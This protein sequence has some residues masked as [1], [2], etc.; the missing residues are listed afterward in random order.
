MT[1]GDSTIP[2][3]NHK[4]DHYHGKNASLYEEKRRH[5]PMWEREQKAVAAFVERGVVLD[6]PCGTG[7]FFDIYKAK[8]LGFLGLD[9]SA[10]MLAQAR[11]KD[12]EARLVEGSVFDIN[13]TLGETFGTVV[14]VRLLHWLNWPEVIDALGILSRVSDTLVVSIGLGDEGFKGGTFDHDEN[15]W[16]ALI[17]DNHE[18]VWLETNEGRNTWWLYKIQLQ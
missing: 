10:D 18:R 12:P 13:A 17:G 5:K 8:G 15:K 9:I 3:S 1:C 4:A 6:V 7:R 11:R 14:C 16:H 2:M